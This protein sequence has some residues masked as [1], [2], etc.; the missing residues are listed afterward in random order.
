[1]ATPQAICEPNPPAHSSPAMPEIHR[2]GPAPL[3]GRIPASPL[4][5][6]HISTVQPKTTQIRRFPLGCLVELCEV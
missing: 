4:S 1:M 2:L 3:T 5:Q 6:R